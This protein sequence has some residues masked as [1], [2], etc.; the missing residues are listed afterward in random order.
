MDPT[1][2]DRLILAR[3]N[4][5]AHAL[6]KATEFAQVPMDSAI[7]IRIWDLDDASAGCRSL[8]LVGQNHKADVGVQTAT[9]GA[10]LYPE[11]R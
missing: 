2:V 5:D 10:M 6:A 9:I 3:C 11:G 7:R 1:S 8:P 4:D